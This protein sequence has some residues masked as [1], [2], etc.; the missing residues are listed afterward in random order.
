MSTIPAYIWAPQKNEIKFIIYCFI[1][2]FFY[3]QGVT[4]ILYT[5]TFKL[6]TG[7]FQAYKLS[8]LYPVSRTQQGRQREFSVETLRNTHKHTH[9]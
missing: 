5:R 6:F 4:D 2:H 3:K 9:T 1:M 8:Q 7:V